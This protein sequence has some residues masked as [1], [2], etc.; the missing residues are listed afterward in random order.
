MFIF[1]TDRLTQAHLQEHQ[2]LHVL[3][4]A[5]PRTDGAR[6]RPRAVRGQLPREG[7]PEGQSARATSPLRTSRLREGRLLT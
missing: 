5:L 7:L 6:D 1:W 4:D 3:R 2:S